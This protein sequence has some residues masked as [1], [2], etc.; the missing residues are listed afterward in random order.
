MLS[1]CCMH[2]MQM[3]LVQQHNLPSAGHLML[4]GSR[5]ACSTH[6]AG[7]IPDSHTCGAACSRLD[8][9]ACMA[10]P[11]R[12]LVMR[13]ALPGCPAGSSTCASPAE[14]MWLA[15]EAPAAAPPPRAASAPVHRE[16]SVCE[17]TG[18]HDKTIQHRT[19]AGKP[20]EH[21]EHFWPTICTKVDRLPQAHLLTACFCPVQPAAAPRQWHQK[22]AAEQQAAGP[23]AW[24]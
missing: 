20:C 1:V 23:V 14:C 16:Q 9:A 18:V 24:Q 3:L 5:Q 6:N 21:A 8:I 4:A 7:E 11:K 19:D 13:G 2:R 12:S 10:E 22:G 17:V 15:S